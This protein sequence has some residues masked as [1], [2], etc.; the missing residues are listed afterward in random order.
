ME[1]KESKIQEILTENKRYVIPAYQRPYSWT[2]DH[3]SQLLDDLET[4]FSNK[5]TEYFI[6]SMIC[7][8]K[9]ENIF[10]VVDGQ[11]RLTTLSLIITQ[12]KKIIINQGV[13]D[14]LQKR[15]LPI[16]VY[17]E[18]TS[19]PR[20][21]V[22]K[23]EF[24]LYKNYILQGNE[25]YYPEKPS[26]T[27]L[28]FIENSNFIYEYLKNKEQGFLKGFAQYILQNVFCVF[29]TTNN[30]ASSF[31]LFNVLNNRGLPLSNSDL[32]KNSLFEYADANKLNKQQV[33]ENWQEIENLIGVKN[34]DKFLSINKLSEKKDR[35]RVTKQDYDSY[36]LT[37]KDDFLG[38]AVLMSISLLK[39]AKNY[40]RIIEN[41]LHDFEDQKLERSSIILIK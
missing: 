25:N 10:E 28:L 36:L 34:L 17:S 22:R 21:T 3:A 33:E 27:E 15:V 9:D 30:F 1:A 41:D 6:G 20:L 7:I 11:Q 8:K 5:E 18:K 39:S 31:R 4:S 24:N 2:A 40:I 13:K 29:V 32:L 37:L 16:D 19:E 38:D 12:L 26:D 35:N 14:D 23:K